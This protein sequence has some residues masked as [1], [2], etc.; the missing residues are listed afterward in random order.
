MIDN[1]KQDRE[2]TTFAKTKPS[3]TRVGEGAPLRGV[4]SPR[5]AE[6]GS[7]YIRE[8]TNPPL[9]FVDRETGEIVRQGKMSG[10]EA[11][12]EAR[13]LRYKLQSASREIL[14]N[15]HGDNTPVNK[16][17][18][19]KHHRTC[20]CNL[21]RISTTAQIVKSTTHKK[22]FFA[23]LATCAN[24]RTCPVC[25]APINERKANEMRVAAN[26][27]EA[28]GLYMS[29]VT[30]TSPHTSGDKIE[31]LI[32]KISESLAGF[33]R[34]AP[35]KRFKE[36]YGI[37]GH[38]RSFEVRHG[39]NGWHPHF[40]IIIV[41][42]KQLPT[43]NRGDRGVVLDDQS[44]EWKWVLDRW[45][46]MCVKNG[47]DKPNQ[48]GLDIQNGEQAGEYITKF[49]SDGEILQTKSG[50]A[51]TWDI[52]D[53]VTKGNT[54]RGRKGSRSPWDLLADS[55]DQELSQAERNEAKFLFLFYARA[56]VGV[57]QIKWSRGLRDFFGLGKEATDE[58]ILKKEE[59]T[60]DLLCHITPV[61]W[62][63]IISN[64]LRSVVLELAENG[65][66]EAVAKFIFSA[67]AKGS[68]EVYFESFRNRSSSANESHDEDIARVVT[69]YSVAKGHS[70]TVKPKDYTPQPEQLSFEV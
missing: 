41:S 46:N 22:A 55:C 36:K 68:F 8:V 37:V 43:T 19:E 50:K 67:T 1:S 11:V 3:Q 25:A 45:Q 56:M 9:E 29:L 30:F 62:K 63:Y 23:G 27:A 21:K 15:F 48:Y 64:N 38:I 44:D 53:E 13:R 16:D 31:D 70:A 32:P 14:Y 33:W 18:Y 61:E 52:A 59:D 40:H 24:A 5:L 42:E 39:E 7:R 49:G 54:K 2:S 65:G 35:A 47:L 69:C 58:E 17:G 51:V 57:S 34:G 28:M 10:D 4:G 26:Q 12:T 66:S 6:G 60:A 20:T